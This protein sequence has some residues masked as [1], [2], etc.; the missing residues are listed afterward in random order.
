M[1]A[2]QFL[3]FFLIYVSVLVIAPVVAHFVGDAIDFNNIEIKAFGYATI[4][5][6]MTKLNAMAEK[7]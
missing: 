5:T 1:T 4:F 6:V 3:Q 2:K 7:K